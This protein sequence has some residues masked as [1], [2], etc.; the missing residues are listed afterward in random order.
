[1][2]ESNKGIYQMNY[3]N[4]FIRAVKMALSFVIYLVTLVFFLGIVATAVSEL[5]LARNLYEIG[6][7]VGLGG[8]LIAAIAI[9]FTS[10]ILAIVLML[11]KLKVA[12]SLL[13]SGLVFFQHVSSGI[14]IWGIQE[15]I[16]IS[17]HLV[18]PPLI[19]YLVFKY[20][21]YPKKNIQH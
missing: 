1:M 13:F 18:I 12:D 3:K 11:F 14:K 5:S 7:P 4:G 16:E 19:V 15:Y 21:L 20:R 9:L 8:I 17:F 6:I 10:Y 2:W